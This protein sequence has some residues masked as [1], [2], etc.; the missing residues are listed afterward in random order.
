MGLLGERAAGKGEAR[1]EKG[2]PPTA[3][4]QP[5]PPA[6]LGCPPESYQEPRCFVPLAQDLGLC[7][8]PAKLR[9]SYLQQKDKWV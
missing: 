4:C 1:L 9:G 3:A 7:C 5:W 8:T 2:E 6:S